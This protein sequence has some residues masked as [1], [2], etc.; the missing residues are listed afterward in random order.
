MIS[1]PVRDTEMRWRKLGK[2]FDPTQYD[3]PNHCVE[4]AQSPQSLVFDDFV[5]IY[6]STRAVDKQNGKYRSHIAYLDVEK[7]LRGVIRVSERTVIPL[8]ERMFR[9]ASFPRMCR[10]ETASMAIPVAE[11]AR[12]GF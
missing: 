4:F 12:I 9:R 1:L 3:L 10:L 5:R 8:G 6:F 7:D 11:Q 2:I